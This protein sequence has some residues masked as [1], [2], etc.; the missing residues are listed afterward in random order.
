M[1]ANL[2]KSMTGFWQVT[3]SYHG[4]LEM[5]LNKMGHVRA[6]ITNHFLR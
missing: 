5:V 6:E 4:T 2:A 3:S 1:I